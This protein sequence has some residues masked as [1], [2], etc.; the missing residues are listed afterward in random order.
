MK[1]AAQGLA[2]KNPRKRSR[3][4]RRHHPPGSGQRWEV[5]RQ[6]AKNSARRSERVSLSSNSK[7]VAKPEAPCPSMRG[8]ENHT[9]SQPRRTTPLKPMRYACQRAIPTPGY[10]R[11]ISGTFR[12][13][14]L[15]GARI[16]ASPNRPGLFEAPPIRRHPPIEG[17]NDSFQKSSG[18]SRLSSVACILRLPGAGESGRIRFEAPQ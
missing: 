1:R 17:A 11:F 12:A 9:H 16:P 15:I 4:R 2:G 5:S 10:S 3:G 6:A 14:R 18:R 13:S 7:V 8:R